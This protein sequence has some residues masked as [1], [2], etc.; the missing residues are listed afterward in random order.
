[1]ASGRVATS[2]VPT[3]GAAG[4]TTPV[5]G[6]SAARSGTFEASTALGESARSSAS[7]M[8]MNTR[9]NGDAEAVQ[10]LRC[11][12][13]ADRSLLSPTTRNKWGGSSTPKAAGDDHRG[14]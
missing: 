6:E 9:K 12:E 1:M 11:S 13:I 14:A 4:A 10:D 8:G 5:F 3:I 7:G 2:V